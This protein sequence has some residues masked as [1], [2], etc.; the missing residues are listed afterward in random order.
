MKVTC[1]AV[2]R[3]KEKFYADA[4]GEYQKRLSRYIKLE[5]IEVPDEKIPDGAGAK[6]EEAVKNKEGCRILKLI[7]ERPS[8]YVA[9]LAVEGKELDS[10]EF[11][12]WMEKKG[13]EGT[14]HIVFVIGGSLGLSDEVKRRADFSLSFSKMTF[15][16]MLMRVIFL[17][18]LYRSCRIIKNEPYHK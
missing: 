6:E 18:Q 11:A 16:H 3:I 17:E 4:V 5:I 14:G 10:V 13:I 15:P 8:A 9:V 2:G 12:K 1:I 7:E